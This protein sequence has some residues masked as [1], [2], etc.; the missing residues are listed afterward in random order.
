MTEGQD[1][2]ATPGRRDRR[3]VRWPLLAVLVSLTLLWLLT[4]RLESGAPVQ[5]TSAPPVGELPPTVLEGPVACSRGDTEATL[6]S[7]RSQLDTSGRIT[8]AIAVACPQLLDGQ[9][10]TYVGEVVGDLLRRDGGA[11]VRVN[12]DAYALRIGPFG[13]HRETVGVNSGLAVWLPDG[14][15]EGLGEPGRHGRRGDVIRVEGL[16]LR[17]DRDDGGGM[18]LRATSLDVLAPSVAVEEAMNTQLLIATS[19]STVISF[20]AWLWARRRA[21]AR[22]R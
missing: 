10:V 11:W 21:R 17:T 22:A 12:D 14:L 8:T 6:D 5:P 1:G 19:V 9:P 16:F 15:H 4:S 2:A 18:T 20:L 7:L 13:P 3:S